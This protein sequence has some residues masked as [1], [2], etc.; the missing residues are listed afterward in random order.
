MKDM[1]TKWITLETPIEVRPIQKGETLEEN[2]VYLSSS[3]QYERCPCP[4]VKYTSDK[5]FW[6]RPIEKEIL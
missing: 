1:W 6:F 3:G 4:G 5:V 2:D